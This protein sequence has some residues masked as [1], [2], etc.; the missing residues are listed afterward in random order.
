MKWKDLDMADRAMGVF[1]LFICIVSVTIVICGLGALHDAFVCKS[2][3]GFFNC[4][5]TENKQQKIQ[6]ESK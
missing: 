1:L 2:R 5:T 4:T 6:I 3:T